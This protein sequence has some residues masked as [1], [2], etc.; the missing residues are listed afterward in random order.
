M[1]TRAA[2]GSGTVPAQ[3][4][5][6]RGN[7]CHASLTSL[8]TLDQ[9]KR[10]RHHYFP[11]RMR[12]SFSPALTMRCLSLLANCERTSASEGSLTRLFRSHGSFPGRKGTPR[13]TRRCRSGGRRQAPAHCTEYFHFLVR[14]ARPTWLSLI[15]RNTSRGQSL[16][17]PST[18][19]WRGRPCMLA[20]VGIPAAAKSEGGMSI[21]LTRSSTAL[22]PRKPGPQATSGT[23]MLSSWQARL[24]SL[25]R[26]RKWQP[27]SLE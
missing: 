27:W 20:G 2:E 3:P 7:C 5:A 8:R 19:P 15:W 11:G 26:V 1:D 23:R 22:P 14:I 17:V 9:Q 21:R 10:M 18:R 24:Y 13:R 6:Q 16:A 4:P 25:L 12:G